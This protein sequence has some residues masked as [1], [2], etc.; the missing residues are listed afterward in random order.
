MNHK[1]SKLV[2]VKFD[3]YADIFCHYPKHIFKEE[4]FKSL[5]EK[6]NPWAIL[7]NE[8]YNTHIFLR[9]RYKS[10]LFILKLYTNNAKKLSSHQ[11]QKLLELVRKT[12]EE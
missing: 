3:L 10:F 4:E 12:I 2:K 5:P 1:I 7:V 11:L 6:R 8:D 9:E